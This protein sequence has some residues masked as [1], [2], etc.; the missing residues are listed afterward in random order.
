M[1]NNIRSSIIYRNTLNNNGKS[2]RFKYK[3]AKVNITNKKVIEEIEKYRI[4]PAWKKVEITLN[5]D[6][7]A[8]GFDEAGRKQ[9]VYSANHIEKKR[10][11]KYCNLIDFIKV[12]PNIRKDIEKNLSKSR[13][14]KEKLIAILLNTIII[15]SF[16]IGTDG[17]KNK[18]NSYGIS[19]I[20]KKEMKIG[21]NNVI[22]DFIG[23]KQ[24][25]NTCKITD[26]KMVRLLKDLYKKTNKSNDIFR[27]G[28]INITIVDVNNYLKSF[29]DNV[30][31]KVFRTW[32][33]NT[34][35]INKII[36]YFKYKNKDNKIMDSENKRLK[37]VRE[38][39]KEVASEMHHTVA[40]CGK[41]Y[42][43]NEMVQLFIEKPDKF[44]KK[45]IMK[46]KK[47]SKNTS[48]ENALMNYLIS[49]CS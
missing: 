36:P 33:A 38:I 3:T 39:K 4:P 34:K 37:I 27:M 9:Y 13:L 23:K 31:S 45:I 12:I 15:C 14:S 5:K 42:L 6:L 47:N 41:S 1:V 29:H 44:N 48:A 25:R 26:P 28:N 20:T 11:K 21:N 10:L 18:Y 22:I 32:L 49:F 40:V 30:T 46:Y 2:K 19:T 35:F 7:I 43:I 24:V 16:R 8:V 17:H